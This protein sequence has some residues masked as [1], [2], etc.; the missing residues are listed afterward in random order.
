MQSQGIYSAQ[1]ARP[2]QISLL[3]ILRA[4]SSQIPITRPKTRFFRTVSVP[5]LW[6]T[7]RGIQYCS[8]ILVAGGRNNWCGG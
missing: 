6:C 8:R 7:P 1:R 4:I 3:A 5:S 2:L